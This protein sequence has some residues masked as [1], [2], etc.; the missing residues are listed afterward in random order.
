MFNY[1]S[2]FGEVAEC[3]VMRDPATDHSRG[4][5]FVTFREPSSVDAVLSAAPH[6][7]DGKQI[8]PKRCNPKQAAANRAANQGMMGGPGGMNRMGGGPGMGDRN[9][10]L[11]KKIFVGGLPKEAKDSDVRE[12]FSRFGRV[13]AP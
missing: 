6:I 3:I 5:G 4:F 2:R 9:D 12:H 10:R 8:D 1:F 13:I 11:S 7:L